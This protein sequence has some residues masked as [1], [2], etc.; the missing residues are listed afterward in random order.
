MLR[1]RDVFKAR[2]TGTDVF[3]EER[4]FD[5]GNES[6]TI[7]TDTARADQTK[8]GHARR[9]GVGYPTPTQCSRD[10]FRTWPRKGG[11]GG[12]GGGGTPGGLSPPFATFTGLPLPGFENCRCAAAPAPPRQSMALKIPCTSACCSMNSRSR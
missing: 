6:Q 8:H 3:Q 4:A 1:K 11:K 9:G 5:R 2:S 7:Y 10:G 12:K